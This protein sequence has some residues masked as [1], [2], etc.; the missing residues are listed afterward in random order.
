MIRELA[1]AKVN[2]DL[3]VTGRRADGY[4]ELDSLVAFADIGDELILEPSPELTLELTGPFTAGLATGP[5][6]LVLC[7]AH[8]L[9]AAA[10]IRPGARLRLDKRLPVAAGLGGGSADAA[11]AL[12][13]L[14]R[15][16]DLPL[17]DRRL[18]AL[19]LELGA[20][21]PVCLAGHTARMRG[22]G[23]R[24][25][26]VPG[27]APLH[28][29][30]VNP[31]L[32]L[33]TAA[34]FRELAGAAIGPRREPWPARPDAAWLARSRNDLEA[35]A[36]ALA[37]LVGEVL[38]QLAAAPD[39][40]LARMSGSGTTCFGLFVGQEAQR[41]AAEAIARARP[42]WWVAACRAGDPA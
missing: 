41:A 27:L 34:V 28:L 39:C 13:G 40:G 25:E 8:R 29:L 19:G 22:I 31:G 30:L 9:A 21:V 20:D 11:A 38:A 23:E 3:L 12:R 4:H 14:R 36:R 42:L 2:L 15:L 24:V 35:P 37:P 17:D 18:A 5:D 1:R 6:N 26:P 32:P 16:W 7:A 33:T 10:G